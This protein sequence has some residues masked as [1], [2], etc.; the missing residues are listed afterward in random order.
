MPSFAWIGD[1]ETY[2]VRRARSRVLGAS[3]SFVIC[4]LGTPLRVAAQPTCPPAAAPVAP[5]AILSIDAQ[6]DLRLADGRTAKLLGIRAAPFPGTQQARGEVLRGLAQERVQG[7]SIEAPE[8]APRDRWNRTVLR[9]DALAEMLIAEGLALAAPADLP[10]PCLDAL[11]GAEAAARAAHEG[12]WADDVFVP[13]DG[14]R[15]ESW[16]DSVPAPAIVE[17]TI[18][19]LGE[20]PYRLYLNF[21]PRRGRDFTVTMTRRVADVFERAGLP[22]ATLK[23]QRLR[24]R[25]LIDWRF[26]PQMEV[27]SPSEVERIDAGPAGHVP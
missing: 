22:L 5:V 26:G 10:R 13:L 27:F 6:F 14:A 8:S 4:V 16:P 7:T 15:P 18:A 20:N 11:Y 21:G 12:A 1:W 17:G 25:G 9:Q 3:L 23:G 2:H 24:V 19:G